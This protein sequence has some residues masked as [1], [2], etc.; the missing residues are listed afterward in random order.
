MI[1][2]QKTIKTAFS[3][4]GTGLHTGGKGILTFKPAPENHGYKFRRTDFDSDVL[5]PADVDYV[6]DTSRGTSIEYSGVRIDTIEH[7][8]AAMAGLE[9]DNVLLEL[10][11]S[12]TPILDGSSRFY[13]EQLQKAGIVE[14]DAPRNYFEL[15]SNVTYTNPETK[16]EITA[17]PSDEF[18]VSVMIDY[19][20]RVLPPQNAVLNHIRQFK[21][22][23]AS[24][25][26][27]VFLHELEYLLKNELIK[28]GDLNNAIRDIF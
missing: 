8:L 10:N 23:I 13:I 5:V 24:C 3:I 16:V 22:E 6:T 14:Q 2:K 15:T 21:D 18:R 28:G 12:E 20:S 17:I 1:D 27:F 11:Q 19:D 25:R 4:E 9:I 26:T 7:V